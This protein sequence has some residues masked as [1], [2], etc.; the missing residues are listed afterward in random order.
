[1]LA[2]AI[3][4]DRLDATNVAAL[5]LAARRI[6][7]IGRA[8]RVNPKAPSF[9]G[10]RKMIEHALDEG[11][12]VAT[13]DFTAHMAM[14]AVAEARILK[15]NRLLRE[16]LGSKKKTNHDNSENQGHGRRKKIEGGTGG[17]KDA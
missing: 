9:I 12:G 3:C 7:M 13:R 8:V 4:Y 16:E 6:V 15:Q 5:E 17:A 14:L 2:M 11:G 1:M 10:L